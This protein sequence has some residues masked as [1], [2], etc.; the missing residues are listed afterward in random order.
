M[1]E[2]YY[3]KIANCLIVWLVVSLVVG[4]SVGC[5]PPIC[6]VPMR[7]P[8]PDRCSLSFVCLLILPNANTESTIAHS[9][10]LRRDNI[11]CFSKL[12]QNQTSAHIN[13]TFFSGRA[14]GNLC[15]IQKGVILEFCWYRTCLFQTEEQLSADPAFTK[16]ATTRDFVWIWHL[17]V[18]SSLARNPNVS[19]SDTSLFLLKK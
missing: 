15:F 2:K 14:Y 18:V 13:P 19:I 5:A 12:Q 11:W 16:M 10:G 17:K 8:G 9:K 7:D 3:F 4:C 6:L 1:N